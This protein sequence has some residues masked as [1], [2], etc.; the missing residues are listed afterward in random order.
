MSHSTTLPIG[1][2]SSRSLDPT[3]FRSRMPYLGGRPRRCNHGPV[4][5]I[6]PSKFSIVITYGAWE[7]YNDRPADTC[8]YIRPGYKSLPA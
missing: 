4:Y 2:P 3:I 6:V 1:T 7:A 8:S 5:R